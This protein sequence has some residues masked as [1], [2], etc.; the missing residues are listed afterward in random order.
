MKNL[1]VSLCFAVFSIVNVFAQ[2]GVAINSTGAAADNSAMLD[3]SSPDKGLLLPRM[4][5]TEKENIVN[6]ARGL[7]IYQIDDNQG[8]WYFD[9]NSWLKAN[10]GDNLGNHIASDS[11]NMTNHKIVNLATCTQNLDA[12]NKAYVDNAVAAGG[13]DGLPKMISNESASAMSMGDAL[14]YCNSLAEGGFNDWYLPSFRELLYVVSKGGVTVPN[15]NSANV[16]WLSD[17]PTA[18]GST[19]HNWLQAFR[20]SDGS[21]QSASSGTSSSYYVRCV[22]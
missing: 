7:L 9:G 8:F 20:L 15:N 14:R 21:P 13:G 4:T 2:D 22:R 16:V 5:K 17:R 19:A 12:A 3:V 1:I 10:A 6:P 11:L 18:S